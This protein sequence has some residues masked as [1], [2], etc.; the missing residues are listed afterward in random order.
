VPIPLPPYHRQNSLERRCVMFR[1]LYRNWTIIFPIPFRHGWNSPGFCVIFLFIAL[2]EIRIKQ[3]Q[4]SHTVR[5]HDGQLQHTLHA[6][7]QYNKSSYSNIVVCILYNIIFI[8]VPAY[9]TYYYGTYTNTI[10]T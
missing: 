8:C 9:D 1:I 3:A 5:P 6:L 4:R 10:R 7:R 2:V